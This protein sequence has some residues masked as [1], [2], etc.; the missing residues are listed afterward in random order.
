MMTAAWVLDAVQAGAL[1]ISCNS[2]LMQKNNL[3]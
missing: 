1:L 3:F 2:S